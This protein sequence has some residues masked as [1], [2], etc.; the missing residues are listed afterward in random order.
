[1]PF[2]HK[3][4]DA[5]QRPTSGRRHH[6]RNEFQAS[7]SAFNVQEAPAAI[8]RPRPEDDAERSTGA[9]AHKE[10]CDGPAFL[11]PP[12]VH[13]KAHPNELHAAGDKHDGGQQERRPNIQGVPRQLSQL[14]PRI[15]L[16]QDCGVGREVGRRTCPTHANLAVTLGGPDHVYVPAVVGV[17]GKAAGHRPLFLEVEQGL[18]ESAPAA[19]SPLERPRYGRRRVLIA[20]RGRWQV[21]DARTLLDLL[22]LAHCFD[23]EAVAGT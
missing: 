6:R 11:D 1:M 9:S 3:T 8:D 23:R 5:D 19:F 7:D 10:A 13:E 20:V 14:Q 22:L 12:A 4:R 21:L 15:G 2:G 16:R 18:V 17:L